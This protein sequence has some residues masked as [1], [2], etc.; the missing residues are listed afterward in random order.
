ML[1]H[2]QFQEGLQGV[3]YE[4]LKQLLGIHRLGATPSAHLERGGGARA[5]NADEV[6]VGEDRLN[7]ILILN[8][9]LAKLESDHP[10]V[11]QVVLCRLFGGLSVEEIAEV[12]NISTR[13]VKRHWK[14]G[15]AWLKSRLNP[16]ESDASG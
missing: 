10:A 1:F 2:F 8:D 16:D 13:T 14:Y 9:L 11:A 6:V 12:M 3:L 5:V 4:R 15:R 7:D